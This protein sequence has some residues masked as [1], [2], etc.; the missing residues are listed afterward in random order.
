MK[1]NECA[2]ATLVESWE[3]FEAFDEV[4]ASILRMSVIKNTNFIPS[5][6][7]LMQVL[8]VATVL[9]VTLARYDNGAPEVPG[10]GGGRRRLLGEG[11]VNKFSEQWFIENVSAYCNVGTYVFLFI[12]VLYLIEDLE[13]PFECVC[14]QAPPPSPPTLARRSTAHPL[15]PTH[16]HPHTPLTLPRRYSVGGLL[17]KIKELHKEVQEGRKPH[18][19]KPHGKGAADV[20]MFPFLELY[21]RL[22]AMAHRPDITHQGTED[23][24]TGFMPGLRCHYNL[25]N[26]HDEE[27]ESLGPTAVLLRAEE[28]GRGAALDSVVARRRAFRQLL[29][30]STSSALAKVKLSLAS[31]RGASS[32]SPQE[33]AEEGRRGK[34]GGPKG[35]KEPL[36]GGSVN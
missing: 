21:A 3:I 14:R 36:L 2:E 23:A 1:F 29:E 24:G 16:P 33:E 32:G 18:L 28:R 19:L 22:S 20:D 6:H 9:L 4:R 35:F 25:L 12:Y 13:D 31:P 7:K 30:A 10:G 27:G 34:A 8:V 26:A 17:P 5:G 15:F 11:E